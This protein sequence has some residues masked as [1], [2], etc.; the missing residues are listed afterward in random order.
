MKNIRQIKGGQGQTFTK[1]AKN[2]YINIYFFFIYIYVSQIIP[3]GPLVNNYRSTLTHFY[4]Y[5]VQ[6]SIPYR[7]LF[8][9]NSVC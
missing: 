5:D 6:T 4:A 3:N 7:T 1:L 2:I 9:P 8:H